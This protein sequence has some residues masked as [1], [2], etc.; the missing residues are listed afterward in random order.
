MRIYIFANSA[1]TKSPWKQKKMSNPP[2]VTPSHILFLMKKLLLIL[3]PVLFGLSS[4]NEFKSMDQG[5]QARFIGKE[6]IEKASDSLIKLYGE[7]AR[8][9]I[10]KGVNQVAAFWVKEDGSEEVFRDFCIQHFTGTEGAQ[11]TLFMTLS[12]NFEILWGHGNKVSLSLKEPLHL[13]GPPIRPVDEIFGAYSPTAHLQDDFFKNKIAFMV[14]L[15]FPYYNLKEKNELG[16]TWSR[17]EWAYARMGDLYTSRE[18][19]GLIQKAA[20]AYSNSDN[21]ISEYN[22]YMGKLTDSRG[23]TFFP[24][25]MKLISHWGLRDELKSQYADKAQGLEKQQLIYQVM[26][27]IIDQ[28]IPQ[29]VINNN[30]VQWDPVTNSVL[31]AGTENTAEPDT[32]YQQLLNNFKALKALDQYNPYYKTYMQRAFDAGMEISMEE[33][34]SL[35]TGLCSSPQVQEVASLIAARL[36]R[37]LQPFDIWYNGFKAK[38]SMNEEEL[39][40]ITRQRYPNAAALQADMPRMLEMLGFTKEKTAEI[41]SRIVV[42]AAR[43]SGHAWGASMKSDVAHLRTRIA[44]D[45]MNYK[46]YNIAVHEFGHNVEQT[47]TLQD[48]DYYMLNGVP[49][50]AFTE[51]VAFLF[52][53][54]D[55]ELLGMKDENPLKEHLLA[56]DNFWA[57]YEIMGVSLVDIRVW[58]WLYANPNA[59]KSQLKEAVTAAAKEVWNQYY[60]PVFGSRDEPIL[61]IYSH[62]I[63]NPLYLPAYPVGHLIDFQI[64]GQVKGKVLAD[65]LMRMYTKGRLTPE[66]WMQ[67]AVG[68]PLSIQ[69]LLNATAEAL[70]VVKAN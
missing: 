63:D 65:E 68:Q 13:D 27:R 55:L 10:E 18:P 42:D 20:E 29:A 58:K 30:Q 6:S 36:G 16:K 35:F 17:K 46:G 37:P 25:D 48:M 50:T 26:K 69:P 11:D 57:S 52:Q 33:V 54:R 60:A 49:T 24:E 9:R 31:P 3:V 66:V 12:R 44:K 21:Y 64:E 5:K 47:I 32:R 14:L 4:C 40:V 8:F 15:N 45:G 41:S 23:R 70:K 34:E 38:G 56:L 1:G 67:Q 2:S 59:T 7:S 22:I 61:A 62:M 43:G 28:S 53:K 19:A 39:N 51:A